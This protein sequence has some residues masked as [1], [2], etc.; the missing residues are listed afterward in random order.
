MALAFSETF[1]SKRDGKKGALT[2]L[3]DLWTELRSQQDYYTGGVEAQRQHNSVGERLLTLALS[4]DHNFDAAEVQRYAH[5][6]SG[7]GMVAVSSI[8]E[9]VGILA[10]RPAF[11]ALAG[12][13][14]VQA[15]AAIEHED[16]VDQRASYFAT[17]GRAILPA[18][19]EEAVEYFRRGLEQMDAI[20]SGDYQ[21]AN[22]LMNFASTLHGEQ[23]A[24]AD[25]HTLSNICELNLGE[26]HKFHWAIYGAAMAKAS[27]LKGLAKLARWEDRE[28]IS[29]D[30]TLLPYLLALL[31]NDQ[32]DPTIA[33]VLLRLSS[34]AELYL[35]G[36]EQL[37]ES[38]EGKG[39][40][41]L[42]EWTQVLIEQ[43]LQDNPGSF[44]SNT[45]RALARLAKRSLGEASREYAYLSA[46]AAKNKVTKDEYNDLNNWREPTP[47]AYVQERRVSVGIACIASFLLQSIGS[48]YLFEFLEKNIINIQIGLLAINTATLGV[49]LTKLRDLVDKGT[50]LSK[51]STTRKEML[52]SIKEQMVLLVSALIILSLGSAT[53]IPIS[54]PQE[55]PRTLLLSCFVYS[56]M[57][58]Y[59]TAKSVFVVLGESLET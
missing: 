10:A 20:G 31:D 13:V 38:L 23:L 54:I 32:L 22:E 1:L 25:S 3:I 39:S 15:K 34:P 57:I 7:E 6:I 51:F 12:A 16:E 37:V 5:A 45:P 43:Y 30:Y 11:Q 48:R 4:A 36:T 2:P 50:P 56:L 24:D 27:S 9:V 26:E 17:L 33:L 55:V 14:A 49:V 35:C 41:Q 59:D 19:R 47:L 53:S 28:R 42:G 44:A 21:F 18:S 58:L 40:D 46:A 29:L 52:L 8:I